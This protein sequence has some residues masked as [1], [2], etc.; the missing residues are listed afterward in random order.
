MSPSGSVP[1]FGVHLS[2]Q[3]AAPVALDLARRAE[4]E[5]V[6]AVWVSEDLYFRGAVPIAAAIAAS[7]RSIDIGLGVLTPYGRHVGLMA[8]EFAALAEIA[9]PRFIAGIGAGVAERTRAMGLTYQ[10]PLA[11]VNEVVELVRRLMAGEN[12]THEG[13]HENAADLRL[14]FGELPATP[15]VYVA[16]VGPKALEQAGR[17]ADGVLLTVMSSRRYARWAA[18]RVRVGAAKRTHALPIVLYIPMAIASRTDEAIATLKPVLA[19]YIQRWARV[20]SL[21]PLFTEWGQVTL[22][23]LQSMARALDEG[24]SPA[25]VVPDD[26]IVNYCIAGDLDEC[27]RQVQGL[28]ATGV[29]DIVLDPHG[30]TDA[31]GRSIEAL[32]VLRRTLL[33]GT[34]SV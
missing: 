4:A 28:V 24:S 7:T 27:R 1:R 34:S 21:H 29:T 5:G 26:L 9:G 18:D 17:I 31:V 12:V 8:M 15:P 32:G 19:R 6:D 25:D 11:T 14:S 3:R 20:E 23:E 13:V 22:E 2:N 16:A 33:R 30:D 10:S